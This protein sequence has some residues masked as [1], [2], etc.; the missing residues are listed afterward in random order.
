[1]IFVGFSFIEITISVCC[2]FLF[3]IPRLAGNCFYQSVF[4]SASASTSIGASAVLWLGSCAFETAVEE[5]L[6][7]GDLSFGRSVVEFGGYRL[8]IFMCAS[9]FTI[10]IY[11]YY[12]HIYD[13]DLIFH[14]WI[15]SKKVHQ[16]PSSHQIIKS[17]HPSPQLIIGFV[18]TT[19]PSPLELVR[20]KKTS[21]LISWFV[22]SPSTSTCTNSH[23]TK[24]KTSFNLI[25]SS[26]SSH[27]CLHHPPSPDPPK[28]GHKSPLVVNHD[29]L[30]ASN[31]EGWD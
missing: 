25:I 23:P 31:V 26:S 16:R 4:G 13:S 3:S 18:K 20:I 15:C 10:Y 17:L 28:K 5:P 1:M 6:S 7:G 8:S 19:P 12:I 29:H 21:K 14:R 22:H 24:K 11:I 2:L 30:E 9:V 27:P